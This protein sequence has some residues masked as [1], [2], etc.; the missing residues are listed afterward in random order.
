MVTFQKHALR[1]LACVSRETECPGYWMGLCGVQNCYSEQGRVDEGQVVSD[2]PR[3]F[4]SA[5]HVVL[6]PYLR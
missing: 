6:A 5:S 4:D 3:V 2:E 1:K